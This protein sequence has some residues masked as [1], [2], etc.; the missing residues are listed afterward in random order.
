M[1]NNPGI[2]D[3]SELLSVTAGARGTV[4]IKAED[5]ANAHRSALEMTKTLG[6]VKSYLSGRVV[7]QK[8]FDNLAKSKPADLGK[9]GVDTEELQ[10][11]YNSALESAGREAQSLVQ[12]ARR[13]LGGA[14]EARLS[15]PVRSSAGAEIPNPAFNDPNVASSSL[16]SRS[17]SQPLT[18][19]SEDLG[20]NLA[21]TSFGSTVRQTIGTAVG[22]AG[23]VIKAGT[24][25]GAEGGGVATEVGEGASILDGIPGVDI[26]GLA[27]G[28]GATLYGAFHHV[29]E[30]KPADG[31]HIAPVMGVE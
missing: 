15:M 30:P 27:V 24:D 17:I 12:G 4:P 23:K 5:I 26:L 3:Y 13:V 31:V 6:E 22:K 7:T 9:L 11:N 20:D 28:L 8:L 10:A 25:A 19:V 14:D 2:G 21:E 18:K 1:A 16:E 29:K